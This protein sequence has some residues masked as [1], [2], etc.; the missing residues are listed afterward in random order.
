MA[1]GIVETRGY[2]IAVE[3]LDAMCKAANVRTWEIKFP[4]GG[5]I[6]LIVEGDVAAVSAAVEAG[7]NMISNSEDLISNFVIPNPHADLIPYLK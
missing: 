3:V 1:L 7:V 5:H 4:G 2:T 6:A